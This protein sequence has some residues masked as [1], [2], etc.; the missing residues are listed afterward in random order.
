MPPQLKINIKQD[1]KNKY[2]SQRR[3]ILKADRKMKP[4]LPFDESASFKRCGKDLQFRYEDLRSWLYSILIPAFAKNYKSH[5]DKEAG[6]F[7][8]D[9]LIERALSTLICKD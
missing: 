5:E 3:N 2:L 6:H 9:T 7:N 4:H 1:H 8:E